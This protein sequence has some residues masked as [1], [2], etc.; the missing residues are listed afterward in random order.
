MPIVP[1]VSG[2]LVFLAGFVLLVSG[3]TPSIDRRLSLLSDILPLAVLEFSHLAGSVIGLAL[4]ILARALFRRVA[5]AYQ[6]T[7]WVLIAG[8]ITALLRGLEIE[9]AMVLA[10]VLVILW[11]GRRAFYRPA[12]ILAQPFPP[13]LIVSLAIVIATGGV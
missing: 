5:A 7:V 2:T 9:Q 8:M 10:L 6:L 1:Q 4:L 13:T 12:Q 3:L 11:L